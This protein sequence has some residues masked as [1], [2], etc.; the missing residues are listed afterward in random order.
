MSA[1]ATGIFLA[2][3][4]AAIIVLAARSILRRWDASVLEAANREL[5]IPVPRFQTMN[6]RQLIGQLLDDEQIQRRIRE[7]AAETGVPAVKLK[8]RCRQYA[9]EIVPAFKALFYFRIGYWLART[10]LLSL[11]RVH[12]RV[13]DMAALDAIESNASVVI[14]MNHRS[15]L[16]VLLINYLASRRANLMQFA[17]EWARMW[18]L[19]M[20][21]HQAGNPVVD[22]DAQDPLYKLVFRSFVQMAA[23]EGGNIAIFPEGELTRDGR[24][25]APRFGLL[26]FAVTAAPARA[27]RLYVIPVGIN[28]ECIVEEKHLLTEP[29]A[30]YRHKGIVEV[31]AS[32]VVA[33]IILMGRVLLPVQAQLGNACASIGRPIRLSD[34][35]A[36]QGMASTEDGDPRE[37]VT[38]LGRHVMEEVALLNPVMPAH[39]MASLLLADKSRTWPIRDLCEKTTELLSSIDTGGRTVV[40]PTPDKQQSMEETVDN[41]IRRKLITTGKGQGVSVNEATSPVLQYLANAIGAQPEPA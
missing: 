35:L 1:E 10:L 4:A 41:F 23:R 5:Q 32:V 33:T 15:N 38:A 8:R 37:W 3:L 18:P 26:N 40:Y 39:A 20:I 29:D 11:H 2:F 24:M 19:Y 22:R 34:W 14:I 31:F 25:Q 9:N 12:F 21:T 16:D 17:G 13:A 30:T 7:Q 36:T 28:Y 6:R 27:D